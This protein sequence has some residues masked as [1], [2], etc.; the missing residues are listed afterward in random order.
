MRVVGIHH[1]T[2]LAER[3]PKGHTG[4][5]ITLQRVAGGFSPKPGAGLN[6]IRLPLSWLTLLRKPV[7]T[8]YSITNHEGVK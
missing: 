7:D 6:R 8:T 1:F 3:Q 5:G 4:V 2:V